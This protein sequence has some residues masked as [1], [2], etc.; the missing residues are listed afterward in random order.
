MALTNTG[1]SRADYTIHVRLLDDSGAVI[2]DTT[3]EIDAVAAGST[4]ETSDRLP[5]R[6][7]TSS[8]RS[9]G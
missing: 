6:F 3:L 2:R 7:E 4:I 5:A 9:A 8:A 1:E